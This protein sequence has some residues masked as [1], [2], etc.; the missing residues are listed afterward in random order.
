MK[1]NILLCYGNFEKSNEEYRQY[2][3][4]VVKESL[5]NQAE[6]LIVCGGNTNNKTSNISE[7]E[8]VRDYITEINPDLKVELEDQ[9]LTTSQNLEFVSKKINPTDQITVYCDLARMAKVIWLS[10]AYLL[11][12]NRQETGNILFDFSRERKLK[13]FN[14]ENL[15]VK[16]FDFPSRDKYLCIAQT[17]SS[18]LEVEAIYDRSLE[19]K[20]TSQ[21]RTDFGI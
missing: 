10:L 3:E 12:K 13:H 16:Y 7:A 11:H 17:F 6:K 19:D 5:E 1:I 20:I 2:I 18:L 8:T 9:S 21:R 15:S 4:M 14:F